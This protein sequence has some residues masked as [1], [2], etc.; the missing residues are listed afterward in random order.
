MSEQKVKKILSTKSFGESS[1]ALNKL[2]GQKAFGAL[3]Q[4]FNNY[5]K[6]YGRTL[7]EATSYDAIV[8]FAKNAPEE[9]DSPRHSTLRLNFRDG[10]EKELSKKDAEKIVKGIRHCTEPHIKQQLIE[11]ISLSANGLEKAKKYLEKK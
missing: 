4:N 11:L 6:V 3:K 7:K 8:D 10:S 2:L 9:T 1:M 5:K